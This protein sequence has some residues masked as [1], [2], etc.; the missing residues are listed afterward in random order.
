MALYCDNSNSNMDIS[1]SS[2]DAEF[3]MLTDRLEQ[4]NLNSEKRKREYFDHYAEPLTVAVSMPEPVYNY[5]EDAMIQDNSMEQD[6]QHSD[7]DDDLFEI[8]HRLPEDIDMSISDTEE[9][10][11]YEGEEYDL[12]E[13]EH[14]DELRQLRADVNMLRAERD[15]DFDEL[16][17]L[18]AE[19][20][21]LREE[22]A[23]QR[24]PFREGSCIRFIM[25]D[26]L[27]HLQVFQY[28]PPPELTLA[29]L[30]CESE[31][32]DA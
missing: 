6:E 27:R 14:Y 1:Q 8:K 26:G 28:V 12:S 20:E 9:D 30:S 31:D 32:D 4:I 3:N 16:Q 19:V 2:F 17:R 10:S 18:R 5:D 25:V 24:I 11:D 22:A 7:G 13:Y 23:Q 21:M 29:D 15:D